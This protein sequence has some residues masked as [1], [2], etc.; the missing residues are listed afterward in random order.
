[1]GQTRYYHFDGL[2]STQLLTD[3][4]ANVTDSYCNT[5]FGVPV[6]TGAKNPTPNPFQFV[7]QL[8]YYLDADTGN[9]YVRARTYSPVLARWLS[10]DPIGF[11]DWAWNQYQYAGNEATYS[12][13]PSGL[14]A[15]T[16][17]ATSGKVKKCQYKLV[18]GN[19]KDQKNFPCKYTPADVQKSLIVCTKEC[20]WDFACKKTFTYEE[21]NQDPQGKLVVTCS[22]EGTFVTCDVC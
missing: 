9:Y 3:E 15:T 1:M 20:N 19:W 12:T 8:G 2:G 4:N 21:K 18:K 5:A 10:E 7:G 17:C 16:I 22:I 6:D 14:K 11:G 13:D